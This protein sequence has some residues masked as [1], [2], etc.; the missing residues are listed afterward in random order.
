L[1][2]ILHMFKKFFSRI[3]YFF[4]FC[5][6]MWNKCVLSPCLC[7]VGIVHVRR[8]LFVVPIGIFIPCA[9][10]FSQYFF[11]LRC[12][13]CFF[14]QLF[15]CRGCGSIKFHY[16]SENLNHMLGGFVFPSSCVEVYGVLY[17]SFCFVSAP[18]DYCL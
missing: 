6:P 5:I 7:N 13:H 1:V 9:Q 4:A 10:K 14:P 12:T 2:R 3:S 11:H 17:I 18:V 16:C 8:N 15:L